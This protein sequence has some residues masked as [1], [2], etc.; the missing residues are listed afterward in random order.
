MWTATTSL[1]TL[2]NWALKIQGASQ[3]TLESP[4]VLLLVIF[5]SGWCHLSGPACVP[6]WKGSGLAQTVLWKISASTRS[7]LAP[8]KLLAT[9]GWSSWGRE[10]FGALGSGLRPAETAGQP[11]SWVSIAREEE[12]TQNACQRGLGLCSG[13]ETRLVSLLRIRAE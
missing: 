10:R 11:G 7:T 3:Q 2:G 9:P 1:F 8:D 5:V 6:L 12:K 4:Q 13:T